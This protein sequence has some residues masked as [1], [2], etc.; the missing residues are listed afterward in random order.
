MKKPLLGLC[1]IIL[2]VAA[3]NKSK[4]AAPVVTVEDIAGSYKITSIKVSISGGPFVDGDYRDQCQKDDVIELKADGTFIYHDLGT[5]CQPPGDMTST[6]QLDG[7]TISSPDDDEINGDITSFDGSSM[8]VTAV[9]NGG[10]T[11]TTVK[12]TLK[13]Q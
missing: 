2:L 6:W 11:N 10:G 3:C 8:E 7:N 5:V 13:K 12:S 4:T 1:S 9:S